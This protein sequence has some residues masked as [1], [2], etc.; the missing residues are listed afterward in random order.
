MKIQQMVAQIRR[1]EYIVVDSEIEALV[2]ESNLIK[3]YKPRYNTLLR[4]T[5][6][7]PIFD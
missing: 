2:L 4:M 6:P 1:F 7:I 3:E 5:K